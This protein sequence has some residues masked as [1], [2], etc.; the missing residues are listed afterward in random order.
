MQVDVNVTRAIDHYGTAEITKEDARRSCL[1]GMPWR[2]RPRWWGA[3]SPAGRIGTAAA[4]A[5][6]AATVVAVGD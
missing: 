3:C 6:V 1:G 5:T 4:I 2:E